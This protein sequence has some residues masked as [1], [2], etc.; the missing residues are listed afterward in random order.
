MDDLIQRMLEQYRANAA[1]LD[2]VLAMREEGVELEERHPDMDDEEL[3][4]YS[5][6]LAQFAQRHGL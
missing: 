5:A 6:D 2:D 3:R 4:E 1:K